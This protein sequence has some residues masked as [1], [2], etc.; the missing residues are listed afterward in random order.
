MMHVIQKEILAKLIAAD[1]LRFSQLKP[2]HLESNHFMYHL[3]ALMRE[4][5]VEKRADGL[6]SLTTQGKLYVDQVSL[7][8]LKTRLQPKIVTLVAVQNK[9]GQWLLY[10]RKHQPLIGQVGFPYG[11]LHLGET[12]AEAATRELMEKT[13]LSCKLTHRGDGYIIINEGGEPVSQ[14]CFHLF[15]GRNPTGTL[16]GE[17]PYGEMF[18]SDPKTDFSKPPYMVS[19][20]DLIKQIQKPT[21]SRFFVE[22]TYK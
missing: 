22:L 2:K 17:T 9:A 10:R 15:Y 3:R 11:K 18:W 19:M 12:V 8:T 16:R 1:S 13:G 5:L 20:P 6:Y 4:G 14:I 7:R 21:K